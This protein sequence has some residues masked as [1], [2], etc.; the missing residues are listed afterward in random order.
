MGTR[1]AYADTQLQRSLNPVLHQ[2]G[3]SGGRS[4]DRREPPVAASPLG[5]LP[6]LARRWHAG[7]SG[8]ATD[9]AI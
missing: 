6:D 5:F 8:R 2:L 3:Q 7:W 1:A 4:D 9:R